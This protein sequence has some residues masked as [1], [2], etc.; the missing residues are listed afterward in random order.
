MSI[1]RRTLLQAAGLMALPRAAFAATPDADWSARAFSRIAT[2][3]PDV[4]RAD[5]RV[6]LS[7]IADALLPRTETPGAL[8]VGVPAFVEL[9]IAEWA[10]PDDASLV[11]RGLLALD[12]HAAAVHGR[13]WAQLDDAQRAAEIAWSEQ[14]GGSPSEGERAF[15]RLKGWI[16]H[17]WLTSERIRKDVLKVKVVPGT[18]S[19][20]APVSTG[21]N[22]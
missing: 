1:S 18:Y 3:S 17:G 19:G 11:R 5:E 9:L 10:S 21:G 16:T 15:R 22:D 13:G 6:I 7:A 8:D 12:A 14:S 20:C 2:T 4:L